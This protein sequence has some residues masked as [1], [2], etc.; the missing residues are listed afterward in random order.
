VTIQNPAAGTWKALI[1]ALTI[2]GDFDDDDHDH[3][4]SKR[5]TKRDDFELRV[6][7]DG[8]RLVLGRDH[9]GHGRR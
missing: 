2:N 4:F 7:I 1:Q 8:V 5:R 3:G 6:T 9:D